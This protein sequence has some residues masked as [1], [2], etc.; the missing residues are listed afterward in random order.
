MADLAATAPNVK[1]APDA[2]NQKTNKEDRP[3]KFRK[4]VHIFLIDPDRAAAEV[5]SAGGMYLW[6]GCPSHCVA[7]IKAT[8]LLEVVDQVQA[9]IPAGRTVRPIY[10]ALENPIPP[11]RIPDATRLR[12][13]AQIEAFFEATS[14]KPIRLQVVLYKDSTRVPA[15]VNTAPPDDG[16]YIE[17]AFLDAS[18]EYDDPA[19][20]SDTLCRNLGG[21][22]KR[23]F[24]KTD[25]R[26]EDRKAR[27][28]VRIHRQRKVLKLLKAKHRAKFPDTNIIDSEDEGLT[29]L[30]RLQPK[31]TN[32]RQMVAVRGPVAAGIAAARAA[33]DGVED[34][35]A[36]A[37]T[38]A[39][40]TGKEAANAAW[41]LILN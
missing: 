10:R 15:P 13:D 16:A 19:E 5:K 37:Q 17:D 30:K 14:T 38:A 8:S 6:D 3:T 2:V 34:P 9:R 21:L 32:P 11:S 28:R 24:P 29:Y 39:E 7:I 1:F 22:A 31:V 20:D 25:D 35:D 12:S 18:E 40:A 41:A 33:L 27:V 26:F 4:S 36:E 23:T